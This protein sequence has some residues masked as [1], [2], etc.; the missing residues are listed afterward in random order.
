MITVSAPVFITSFGKK[1][2]TRV[3]YFGGAPS[4]VM[5]AISRKQEGA[6]FL[7]RIQFG[8]SHGTVFRSQDCDCGTQ[9]DAFLKLMAESEQNSILA[10]FPDHEA[11][12]VGA[13]EK[14]KVLQLEQD[15]GKTFEEL[16]EMG[17]V[18]RSDYAV[19]SIIPYLFD[20]IDIGKDIYLESDSKK[21]RA[22][23]QEFGI[24][25]I[26]R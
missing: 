14:M 25:I 23:L 13:F 6:P 22:A 8:C 16:E 20:A 2:E 26:D 3:G 21:K 15:L 19:L 9:V 7:T 11:Y 10:Y 24:K 18:K 4:T 1:F 12:G 5:C 17:K